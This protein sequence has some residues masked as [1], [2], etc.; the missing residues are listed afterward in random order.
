MNLD[1]SPQEAMGSPT[2]L[3]AEP[4]INSLHHF[5]HRCVGAAGQFHAFLLDE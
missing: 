4:Q 2:L 1:V 5:K 3:R